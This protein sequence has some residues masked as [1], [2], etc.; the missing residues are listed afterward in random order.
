MNRPSKTS[1]YQ[2]YLPA[3]I[4]GQVSPGEVISSATNLAVRGSS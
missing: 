1:G 2:E 3:G 4:A